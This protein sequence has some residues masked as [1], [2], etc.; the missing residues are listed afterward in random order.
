MSQ[1]GQ[2]GD[3]MSGG[4][5]QRIAIARALLKDPRILLLD[6]A[7]SALDSRSEKAV[8]DALDEAS[9]G[10]TTIVIAHRVSTLRNA[11]LVAVLQSGQVVEFGPHDQLTQNKHGLYST[12]VQLQQM[13]IQDDE[14]SLT[15]KETESND[16]P[17][18][19][20]VTKINTEILHEFFGHGN[21]KNQ[22]QEEYSSPSLW[23]LLQ[24]TAPEWKRTIFG[25]IGAFL[26]GAI[27]PL[28]S[29]CIGAVLSVYF[30]NDHNEI[31]SNTKLYSFMFLVFAI[32]SFIANVIQHYNFGV[33]G[34][35][36][37]KR[38]REKMLGKVLTFE[39]EWFDQESNSSAAICSR[40]ATEASKV[41]S[42]ICDRLA[43]LA[44]VLS[45]ATLAV[46]LGLSLAWQLASLIIALQPLIIGCFYARGV[47]MKSMSKKVAKA[48]NKSSDLASEAVV[49]HRTITAFSSQDKIVELFEDAQK[50]T[51]SESQKQSWYAGSGLFV[52]QFLTAA[53]AGLIFWYGGRLLYHGQISYKHL[54]QTFF[55]LVTTGRV[56][57][58][59]GSMTSD[60]SK[61]IDA[62]KS[63][64][65][66]LER[67]SK[68][69]P[70]RSDGIKPQNINGYVELKDVDFAY[71][72]RPRQVIFTCLNL[73]VEAGK[74]LALV[75]QSG[76]GKSTIIGLIERF[77]DPLK[78]S[79]EIDGVNIKMYNLRALRSHI[80]LV[81]QEPTLFAGTIHENIAYGRKNATEAEI[82]EAAT[83]ANAHEFIR[84]H[85]IDCQSITKYL[86]Y[87]QRE[88]IQTYIFDRNAHS[89]ILVLQ[90]Y[91]MYYCFY[92]NL[93]WLF[94]SKVTGGRYHFL[95]TKSF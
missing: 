64:L 17:T 28:H 3:Q 86:K 83:I 16:S 80:G 77:Y 26:Y 42:L 58:E 85:T 4:Q 9:I 27:F 2:F 46:I 36:L 19:A 18:L 33:M 37:T 52:S 55:I 82:I 62:I 53:N 15:S 12:M 43:L 70:D 65:M 21:K 56:I 95:L 66:I 63:V 90:Q 20:T 72:T 44:Q 41:R 68:M 13:S 54:F 88:M 81:S 7:T 23:Y 10:R 92:K 84:Y 5:K 45:G 1:V 11:N 69:E 67:K 61:G 6:E 8:Q 39:I 47:L 35:H 74:S 79:V 48:Q 94:L 76:S 40:L 87:S 71:P 73:K 29:Y 75:G 30:L 22:N 25:C 93:K 51:R 91:K 59:A 31:R 50:D 32:I 78:G 38:V 89:S 24:M 60:L 57:A 49:N 14:T 34:E